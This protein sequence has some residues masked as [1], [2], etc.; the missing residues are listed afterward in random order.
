MNRSVG[1]RWYVE[2]RQGTLGSQVF[3]GTSHAATGDVLWQRLDW[4]TDMTSLTEAQV[5]DEL[6]AACISLMEARTH[7]PS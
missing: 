2:I 6:W 4:G 1:R 3:L 5:L 7:L